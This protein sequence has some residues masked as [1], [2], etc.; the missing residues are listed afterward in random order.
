MNWPSS[1]NVPKVETSEE[2]DAGSRVAL[3]LS[4][5][6]YLQDLM[7]IS[8]STEQMRVTVRQLRGR[9]GLDNWQASLGQ[10]RE[11]GISKFIVDVKTEHLADFFQHVSFPQRSIQ[12]ETFSSPRRKSSDSSVPTTTLS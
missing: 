9:P 8:M 5:L 3:N 2:S 4:D 1:L 6:L 7:K 10:L 11:T 12:I